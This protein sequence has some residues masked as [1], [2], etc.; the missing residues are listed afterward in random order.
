MHDQAIARATGKLERN[1][2]AAMGRH[3]PGDHH[4]QRALHAGAV[5]RAVKG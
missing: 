2:K 3:G 4:G 5:A 1:P